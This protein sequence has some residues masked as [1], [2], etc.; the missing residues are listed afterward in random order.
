MIV[1]KVELHP[2]SGGEPHEIGRAWIVNDDTGTAELGNYDVRVAL[3]RGEPHRTAHV[4]GVP[5]DRSYSAWRL[6]LRALRAAFPEE[7]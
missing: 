3:L 5:R 7:P 6:V 1:V 2:Y 4:E